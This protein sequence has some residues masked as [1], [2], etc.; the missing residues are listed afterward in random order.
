MKHEFEKLLHE[1][2]L[3]ISDNKQQHDMAVQ[4]GSLGVSPKYMKM[5][6]DSMEKI[7]NLKKA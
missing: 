6:T 7:K 2:E 5:Y 1:L 3:N 4:L